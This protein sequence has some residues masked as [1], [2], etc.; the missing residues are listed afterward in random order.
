MAGAL[1]FAA[2][3]MMRRFVLVG[4]VGVALACDAGGLEDAVVVVAILGGSFVVGGAADVVV[5]E[6]VEVVVVAVVLAENL[7]WFAADSSWRWRWYQ[8]ERCWWCWCWGW[9]CAET[10]V[11]SLPSVS[12]EAPSRCCNCCWPC[13]CWCC[14]WGESP[15]GGRPG[16]FWK[17]ELKKRRTI[18]RDPSAPSSFASS[19]GRDAKKDPKKEAR[20]MG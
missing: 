2:R 20:G 8:W 15:A 3:V 17:Q 19:R 11:A 9:R 5:D 13:C 16:R 7:G 4:L 10:R 18:A 14:W 6:E 12:V 1:V